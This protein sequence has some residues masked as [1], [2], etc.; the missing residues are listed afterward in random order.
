[1]EEIVRGKVDFDHEH[2]GY[3][4]VSTDLPESKGDCLIEIF[5]G[6]QLV[7]EFL[8][9]GYKIWNIPAHADDIVDGLEE[10]SN[11]GIKVAGSTGLGGNVFQD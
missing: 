9:P 11:D 8:W 6:E 7:R 4:F 2:R 5:K 1:V 10:N 3:R